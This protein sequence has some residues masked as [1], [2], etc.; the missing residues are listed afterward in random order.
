MNNASGLSYTKKFFDP[1]RQYRPKKGNAVESGDQRQS[2]YVYTDEIILAVNVALAT[3]RPLLVRGVSG[4]GKSSLAANAADW[5]GWRYYE[6]VITSRTQAS[7]L[8]CEIDWLR[9][10]HDAQSH[11][12][13]NDY[14]PYIVPG[15][16]WWAFDRDSAQIRGRKTE[17]MEPLKDP[18]TVVGDPPRAVVLLDEIDKADPDVPN[19]LL[20]PLGS[21]QFQVHETGVCVSTKGETAPLVV[22][23][24]N[25]ERE[26]PKA[27]LRRCV[28]LKL[29]LPDHP[30]LIEIAQAH[31][32]EMDSDTIKQVVRALFETEQEAEA[33]DDISPNNDIS[34]AELL[35]MIRAYRELEVKL[36]TPAWDALVGITVWK[37]GRTKDQSS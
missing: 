8:L 34:P 17:G 16:L 33:N 37:H 31:F 19:S 28:E 30:R 26:L 21:L 14:T 11:H 35:D 1:P 32:P 25:E 29:Q 9:R 2:V 22:I 6:K 3:G 20:E 5:L 7:D 18:C 27:F 24:T 12:F 15:V 36:E 23:T 10:L 4:S 13:S